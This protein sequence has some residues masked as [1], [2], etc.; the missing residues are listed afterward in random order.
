MGP[1][2]AMLYGI[3]TNFIY[4]KSLAIGSLFCQ[5]DWHFG[6]IAVWLR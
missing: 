2:A 6:P 1:V 4:D 3:H 5:H